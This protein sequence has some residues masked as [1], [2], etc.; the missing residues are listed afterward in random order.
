MTT[1]NYPDVP[2]DANGY[3]THRHVASHH[4]NGV[5]GGAE[6]TLCGVLITYN[7]WRGVALKASACAECEARDC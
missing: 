5:P 7:T 6:L 4:V 1:V 3:A 2:V